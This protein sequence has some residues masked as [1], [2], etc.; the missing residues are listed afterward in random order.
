MKILIVHNAYREAGGED[1]V[2]NQEIDLLK[3]YNEEVFQYRRSNKEVDEY[4]IWQKLGLPFNIIWSSK[5]KKEIEDIIVK[6]KPD[7]V[8]FHNTFFQISPAPYYSCRRLRIPV[9]QTIQNYRFLCPAAT[10]Y[11]DGAVCE[12]CL[13]KTMPISGMIHGCY[14]HSKAASGV[15]ASMLTI[16]NK[17]N[18]FYSCIDELIAVT[19]FAKQK[20]IDAGFPAQRISVKAN[21]ISPDPGMKSVLG[22]YAIFIGRFVEEK[23]VMT[24]LQALEGS[25]VPIKLLGSGKLEET[26]KKYAGM[27]LGK[28]VMEWAPRDI[29]F[30]TLKQARFLVFP[31]EWYEGFPLAIAEAFACGVPV[32]SSNI[33]SM[34]EIIEHGKN[35]LF[36]RAGDA[37]DLKT[38]IE[39]AWNHP[40]ELQKMGERARQEYEERYTPERNYQSLL[41]IYKKAALHAQ[42]KNLS[43]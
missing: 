43:T 10:F 12:K 3:G 7:V 37:K 18:T 1:T 27:S 17:L 5:S 16:H 13:G 36:F 32:I 30:D 11:R 23:G 21:I 38:K 15:V 24:L 29:M 19:E 25:S 4:S 8:H 35:G 40:E 34:S 42:N 20:F 6:I 41:E 31:S 28:E 22:S 14:H 26:V 39:W 9:V 2:V 33:G